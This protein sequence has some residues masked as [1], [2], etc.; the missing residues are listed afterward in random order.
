MLEMAAILVRNAFLREWMDGAT[1]QKLGGD[2]DSE[3]GTAAETGFAWSLYDHIL[4][5]FSIL[6]SVNSSKVSKKDARSLKELLGKLF[7]W[8]DGFRD[9]RLET[10]LRESDDL[11]ETVVGELTRIGNVLISSKLSLENLEDPIFDNVQSWLRHARC[12]RFLRRVMKSV[13]LR[14]SS[15]YCLR[16]QDWSLRASTRVMQHQ[17][18]SRMPPQESTTV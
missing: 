15:A 7:L 5:L 8:G 14:E 13:N 9:G 6:V 11:N 16:R 17:A 10:I 2:C 4:K 3:D 18:K 12:L 1:I